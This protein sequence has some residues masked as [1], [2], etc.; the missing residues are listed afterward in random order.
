MR[1]ILIAVGSISQ[2]SDVKATEANKTK[3]DLLSLVASHRGKIMLKL[4]NIFILNVMSKAQNFKWH[5]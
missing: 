3:P 1:R 5:K 4:S 2:V